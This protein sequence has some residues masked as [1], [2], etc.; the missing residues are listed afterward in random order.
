MMLDI[1]D[2]MTP[3]EVER[4]RAIAKDMNFIDGRATNPAN[5]TKLNLTSRSEGAAA[6]G[7]F[8]DRAGRP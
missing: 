3:A 6:R 8:Q 4:V 1:K 7:I 2:V 5:E